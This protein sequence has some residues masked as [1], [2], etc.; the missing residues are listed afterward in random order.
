M[1]RLSMALILTCALSVSALAGDVP[2]VGAPAVP[3]APPAPQ[4]TSSNPG[5]IPTVGAP[6]V[7]P[8]PQSTSSNVGTTILLVVLSLIR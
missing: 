1:K 8:A 3:P 6:A 5:E 7:P 2:T 4:D